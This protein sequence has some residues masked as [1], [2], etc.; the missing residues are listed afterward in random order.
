MNRAHADELNEVAHEVA[1][2]LARYLARE[3]RPDPNPSLTQR[4]DHKYILRD[5]SLPRETPALVGDLEYSIKQAHEITGKAEP[6]IRKMIQS[7]RLKCR[8]GEG[9]R[10]WISGKE[11][12]RMMA[13]Q[14][15]DEAID[16][17]VVDK[18]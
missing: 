17:P 2:A 12:A 6:T 10:V 1:R 4:T 8:K 7:N 9:G 11:L 18:A 3:C 14:L 5:H 15:S 13:I 16:P